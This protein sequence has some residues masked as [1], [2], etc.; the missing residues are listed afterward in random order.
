[1]VRL[2][3]T[4]LAVFAVWEYVTLLLPVRIPAWLQPALVAGFA[5]GAQ[6]LPTRVLSVIAITGAVALCHACVAAPSVTT[7]DRRQRAR[8]PHI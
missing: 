6:E 4:A 7:V 8:V 3:T 5:V 1:M 2:V